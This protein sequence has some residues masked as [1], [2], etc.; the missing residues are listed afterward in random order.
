MNSSQSLVN[1]MIMLSEASVIITTGEVPAADS[2]R[3]TCSFTLP[4][5]SQWRV[6]PSPIWKKTIWKIYTLSVRWWRQLCALRSRLIREGGRMCLHWLTLHVHI[7]LICQLSASKP[8][9]VH[10]PSP[11]SQSF[12]LSNTWVIRLKERT[13]MRCKKNGL[14]WDAS[15][16]SLSQIFSCAT[17]KQKERWVETENSS[18]LM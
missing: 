3:C 15:L 11:E 14:N 5:N 13:V 10:T 9:P 2:N 8:E 12:A 6:I 4:L 18:Y 1:K 16:Y 17:G 7:A